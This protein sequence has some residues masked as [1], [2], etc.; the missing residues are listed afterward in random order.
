VV[1]SPFR[2]KKD[3]EVLLHVTDTGV[4]ITGED[5]QHIFDGLYYTKDTEL[6]ASKQPYDSRRAAKGSTF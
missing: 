5:Q 1:Q 2:W 6:Y 3:E 4:G